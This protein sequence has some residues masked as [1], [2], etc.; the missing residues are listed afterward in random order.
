MSNFVVVN[1]WDK[2]ESKM[3]I[4]IKNDRYKA[5]K[6]QIENL[7]NNCIMRFIYLNI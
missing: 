5:K 3:D 2:L 6:T 7:K 4:V 1:T